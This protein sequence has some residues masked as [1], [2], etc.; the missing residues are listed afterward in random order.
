VVKAVVALAHSF[1]LQTVGEGVESLEVLKCLQRLGVDFAQGYLIGRPALPEA[2]G[3]YT[4]ADSTEGPDRS[5]VAASQN[6]QDRQGRP[7]DI[8]NTEE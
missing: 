4:P 8:T 5:P 1:G 6:R 7:H 2:A 3:E